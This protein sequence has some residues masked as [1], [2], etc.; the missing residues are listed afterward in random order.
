MIGCS[1]ASVFSIGP[2]YRAIVQLQFLSLHLH[3]SPQYFTAVAMAFNQLRTLQQTVVW[4]SGEMARH[5][6]LAE[7]HFQ[8]ASRCLLRYQEVYA[9]TSIARYISHSLYSALGYFALIDQ[10]VCTPM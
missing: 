6:S 9:L 3:S 7:D 4:T 8:W 1:A 10:F 5:V 2:V